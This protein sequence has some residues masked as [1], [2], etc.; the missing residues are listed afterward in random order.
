MDVYFQDAEN[1]LRGIRYFVDQEYNL[2]RSKDSVRNT[3]LRFGH[4]F[5]YETN[6]LI[7]NNNQP[8]SILVKLTP[9]KYRIGQGCKQ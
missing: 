4:R 7:L 9:L 5:V 1:M 3:A 8:T 6:T 2:L